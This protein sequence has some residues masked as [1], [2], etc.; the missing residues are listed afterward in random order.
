M[1]T[2]NPVRAGSSGFRRDLALGVSRSACARQRI[3]ANSV[4]RMWFLFMI[5]FGLCKCCYAEPPLGEGSSDELATSAWEFQR[6]VLPVL[7]KSGCN[8]GAC[9]GALAGKGGFKLSLRGYD[10]LGD[11]AAITLQS[12]GRRINLADPARSLLL[13]KPTTAVPHK[14]GLRLDPA[15]PDYRILVEWIAA[16]T[17]PP[18]ESDVQ[19]SRVEVIPSEKVMQPSSNCSLTVRAYYSDGR[20][21]DVTRWAVYSSAD[22]SVVEVDSAGRIQVVGR[23]EASVI[24]W[25][26]S[27][28]AVSRI[29]VPFTQA[30][31]SA[32]DLPIVRNNWI[33]DLVLKKLE[34]LHVVPSPLAN[35]S[36]FVRRVYLST[37]GTLPR[38][39]ETGRFLKDIRPDKRD[40][41]IDEL[42]SRPEFVD[43]WTY[44]WSD[45][46]LVNGRRLRPAAV[47]AYHAWIRE[48]VR[49]NTPWDEVVSQVVTASGSTTQNGAANF[50]ALHQDPEAMTENVCQAFL[51]LSIGCA[52]CHNHPLEKW[53]N[54]QYYGM[55]SHFARVRGKGWGGDPRSGNGDRVVFVS[56][57]G[58]LIQPLRGKPQPPT[59][60]NGKPLDFDLPGDRRVHLAKWL[61]A[62]E[63]PYF[64]RALVNRVWAAL[65]GMGIVEPVDDMRVSN[66]ASNE[67]LLN[68]LSDFVIE[69]N[70]NIKDLIRLIVQSA[71][72]QRSS[73]SM[74]ENEEDRRYF[75]RY[76]PHRLPAE[77]LLDAIAQITEVPSEFSEIGFEGNDVEKTEAYPLGTRAIQLADSAVASKFLKTFGRN[78]RDITCECERSN[79]PNLVQVLHLNN[80]STVNERLRN[81]TNSLDSELLAFPS[82][83]L[84]IDHVFL[85]TLCRYPTLSER[86]QLIEEL[87]LVPIDESRAALEDLYWSVM[88]S[89]EFLFNH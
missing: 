68:A 86:N 52:R 4:I 18:H 46:L 83:E 32:N 10:P 63:N 37:I 67:P 51:G 43:F 23:G 53:T 39:E 15:S 11:Y 57:S 54:D 49:N 71:T 72:F 50:Y 74:P 58:E 77:E 61:T 60:L 20:S 12:R 14:G 76:Y 64:T 82:W 87:S 33:D 84:R 3:Y 73:Q 28:I 69:H 47:E 21:E 31:E 70:Y 66:P 88:S 45:L 59:P 19:L 36:E 1:D 55:A 25:F 89:R 13:L 22:E 56:S 30:T 26:S 34:S 5:C 16:G 8:S 75:S 24:V 17:K 29:T 48:H 79:T 27:H 42:L 6:H 40:R 65:F 62:A 78:D 80:G 9:H 44:K 85:T 81:P 41:L 2:K 35:D 38:E 7:T